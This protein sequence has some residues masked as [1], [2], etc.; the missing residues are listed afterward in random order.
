M[1]NSLS[2]H[3]TPDGLV[4]LTSATEDYLLK[5]GET[6]VI[7]YTDANSVP[8]HVATVEG[9]YEIKISTQNTT[10]SDNNG[11][12]LKPNNIDITAYSAQFWSGG[13]WSGSTTNFQISGALNKLTKADINT[14]TGSKTLI[15]SSVYK[16]TSSVSSAYFNNL[17]DDTSTAWTSLGTITF[18]FAQSGKIVIRRIA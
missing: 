17:W 7:T 4:D 8:L 14:N 1:I 12:Y 16:T 18:P 6:A 9:L 2:I 3:S 13:S 15:S 5:V 11:I 10:I